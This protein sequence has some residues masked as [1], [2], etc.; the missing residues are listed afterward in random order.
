M[1]KK[2]AVKYSKDFIIADGHIDLPFRLNKEGLLFEKSINLNNETSGNFDIP[3]AKRGGLDC[4]FMAIYIP[5]EKSENEAY[6]F[7]NSLIDLVEN[8]INSNKNLSFANSP[9]D[10][11]KNFNN[12]KISLPM[13]MEN[14]SALGSELNNLKY[15]FSRGIRYITL[16]HAKNNQICDSSYDSIRKWN[17]LSD[18]GKLLIN[19]MN[20]IGMMI[21]VSHVSDE[22]FFDIIKITQKPIIASHSSPRALT[23]GFERNLN[24]E[25]I[26]LIAQNE[27]VVLV[28]FGS[29]FV[30]SRSNKMFSEIQNTVETW[31]VKNNFKIEDKKVEEYKNLLIKKM[32]P[33]A[34]IEDVL[35]AIDHVNNL[36]GD[37][38][39]GFGSDYDGLGNTLPNNL[40]D[41][42]TYVNLLEGLIN[43]G[44]SRESIE[45]ICYKNFFRVWDANLQNHQT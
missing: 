2:K 12:N 35:D 37:D 14:G 41:V 15:F 7:A 34:D 20:N 30:N 9:A 26:E 23:P 22:T 5:S 31:R 24:D 10:V 6:K 43:R 39:I 42:S 4:P 36:V 44:Y 17:G 21:D 45:K 1:N 38:Y 19:E 29:A 11:F 25:M 18:F 27:G 13:G 16:T 40:K 8:I 3:K 33:F 32:N 28:N